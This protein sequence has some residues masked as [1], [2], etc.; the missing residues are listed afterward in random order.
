MLKEKRVVKLA[1]SPVAASQSCTGGG[2]VEGQGGDRSRRLHVADGEEGDEA[3]SASDQRKAGHRRRPE[4]A[5]ARK[6]QGGLIGWVGSSGTDGSGAQELSRGGS[7]AQNLGN[8][9]GNGGT[10]ARD[11]GGDDKDGGSGAWELVDSGVNLEGGS[12]IMLTGG[13][14]S[15]F[16]PSPF[17]RIVIL[18]CQI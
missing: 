18:P 9:N 13:L 2:V 1:T 3:G 17:L 6:P 15:S 7:S 16:S 8:D 14:P 11:L 4:P 12:N 5:S 10:G